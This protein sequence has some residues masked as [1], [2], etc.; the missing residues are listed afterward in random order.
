LFG[1]TLQSYAFKTRATKVMAQDYDQRYG[2]L[3]NR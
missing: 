1:S 3:L 2:C